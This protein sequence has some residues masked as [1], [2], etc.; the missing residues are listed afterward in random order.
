MNDYVDKTVEDIDRGALPQWIT[1]HVRAYQESD[2]AQGHYWDATAVGGDG[3]VPCLL[4]TTIGRRS[5]KATTHPLVYGTD[6]DRYVIVA[7]K[8]GADTHP[9]WYFNLRATPRV[10]VQVGQEKF[11]ATATLASGDERRRL[12]LLMAGVCPPYT[13]YQAKTLRE[14]PVFVLR[15]QTGD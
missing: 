7:S 2:G 9:Q 4:L 8:G 10:E 13:D 12:W 6:G 3:P 14:I 15:R 5:G 11:I 1:D